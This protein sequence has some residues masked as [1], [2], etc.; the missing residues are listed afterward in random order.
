MFKY[1]IIL[2]M[3]LTSCSSISG[4]WGPYKRVGV[5]QVKE[6]WHFCRRDLHGEALHGKG[7]CYPAQECKFRKTILGNERKECRT[8][9]LFC[10]W[11]DL[12]CLHDNNIF[13]NV[14]LNKGVH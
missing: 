11:G 5:A 3:V 12:T 13:Y 9:M 2:I 14:I 6:V 10:K 7:V 1:L 4:E 8:K